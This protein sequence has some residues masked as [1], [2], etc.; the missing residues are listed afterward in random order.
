MNK[1]HGPFTY[2][3]DP[4]SRP[5]N[6]KFGYTRW[7]L[8]AAEMMSREETHYFLGIA[9]DQP[10]DVLLD[11]LRECMAVFPGRLATIWVRHASYSKYAGWSWERF[12]TETAWCSPLEICQTLG[13]PLI[14][15]RMDWRKVHPVIQA[16]QVTSCRLT[17]TPIPTE[18][19][20][21]G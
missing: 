14:D 1:A 2:R 7:H 4:R 6:E 5:T 20:G 8:L 17:C 13:R 16:A 19:L 9:S 3:L 21:L 10:T 15:R 18:L 11:D 12:Q